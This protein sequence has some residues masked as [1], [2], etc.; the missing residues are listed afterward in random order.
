LKGKIIVIIVVVIIIISKL[1][2]KTIITIE[3]KP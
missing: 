1:K 3:E 2:N